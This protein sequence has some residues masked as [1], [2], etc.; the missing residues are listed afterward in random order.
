MG[1][2]MQKKN[3]N[4]EYY[5]LG[6]KFNFYINELVMY[7]VYT[8][9]S[10]LHPT[11]AG[12]ARIVEMSERGATLR[13]TKF[14]TLFS[15]VFD[16]LRKINFE[17]LLTL[18]PQNFDAEIADT[19]K[20]YR[21]RRTAPDQDT[22]SMQVEPDTDPPDPDDLV[23]E[24]E[25][26]PTEPAAVKPLVKGQVLDK[27]VPRAK[28]TRSGRLYTVKVEHLPRKYAD[29]VKTC[30]VIPGCIPQIRPPSSVLPALP[31]LKKRPPIKKLVRLS[32][33]NGNI[34]TK[35]ASLMQFMH[36]EALKRIS[37]YVENAWK[38]SS[39]NSNFRCTQKMI[40]HGNKPP[41]RVKFGEI[42]VFH[43]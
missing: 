28:R 10:M 26:G 37:A 7:K 9:A 43:L 38:K 12:P 21:Y 32:G 19:L 39:F 31:C 20:N 5:R 15:V 1:R 8:P 2:F 3:R 24:P 35:P 11:Y 27:P 13:D 25:P 33:V 23:I 29:Q 36:L 42:T 22:D 30:V 34:S 4:K 40:L 18:L 41:G 16:N 6:K 14:G 17:E